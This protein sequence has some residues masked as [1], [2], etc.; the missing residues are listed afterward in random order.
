MATITA[1][2]MDITVQ[3]PAAGQVTIVV[4]CNEGSNA[5]TVTELP[6]DAL[7][8]QLSP[9]AATAVR[10]VAQQPK[11]TQTGDAP[12]CQPSWANIPDAVPQQG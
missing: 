8:T 7:E 9:A 4:I 5:Y 3:R 1:E 10:M 11:T 12:P 2:A 6:L